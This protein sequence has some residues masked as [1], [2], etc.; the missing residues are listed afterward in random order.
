[1]T[2]G[3]VA[4][5][6]KH[7]LDDSG[8]YYNE[9]DITESIQDGYDE[10]AVYTE[11]IEKQTEITLQPDTTYYDMQSLI[12]DYYR[13]IRM[14]LTESKRFL[15]PVIEIYNSWD[16]ND[17]E[18][19]YHGEN[20]FTLS[21][22]FYIGIWGRSGT[23][24]QAKIWYKAQ[25]PKLQTNSTILINRNYINL[26]EN[27]ATADLLEQ[28][29][30]FQKAQQYWQFYEKDLEDYRKKIQLLAKT[31]RIFART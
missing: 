23:S 30:E 24:Q 29:E 4:L 9:S 20:N 19:A 13:I 12:P 27:Y 7:N 31:D 18:L 5:R 6:I 1:M 3:E 25:A 28:N 17:W 2:Q 21:G 11:F 15:E 26:L 8:I 22:P 16:R 14:Y 10:I